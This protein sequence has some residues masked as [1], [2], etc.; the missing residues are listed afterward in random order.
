M[1]G[2]MKDVPVTIESVL[3]VEFT[4]YVDNDGTATSDR[5]LTFSNLALRHFL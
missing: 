2:A 1:E 3:R 5:P 4:K